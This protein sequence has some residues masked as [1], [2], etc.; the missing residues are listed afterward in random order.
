MDFRIRWALDR[1]NVAARLVEVERKADDA[2]ARAANS[3]ENI[4]ARLDDLARAATRIEQA[5]ANNAE[6][7]TARLDDLAR[8]ATR[9]EQAFANTAENITARLD[10]LA[11]TATPIERAFATTAGMLEARIEGLDRTNAQRLIPLQI[12]AEKLDA[13]SDLLVQRNIIGLGQELAVR[14]AAGYLLAPVEDP[15]VL[16][17]LIEGRGH[18]EPGTTAVLQTLLHPGDIMVDVGGHIGTL[19]LPAARCVG[20]AGRVI[21]LEPAPRLADLLRRTMVL[22]HIG[23]VDVHECAAGEVEAVA[24]FALSAQTGHNSLFP[25]DDTMQQIEVTVRPLDALIPPGTTVHVVKVDAEGAELQVWRGMRRILADN[26]AVAVLLEF[27]PE[28]LVRVGVS[29]AEWF[30]E[31]T[32]HG[33]TPWEIEEETGRVRPLRTA[34]LE[35]VYSFNVLLLRD[36]P[37]DRGLV[38]A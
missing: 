33:H 26:P 11:R 28:H 4:T 22:N 1:S 2:A 12:A 20:A 31:V 24:H 14:T 13:R 30:A 19:A 29:V 32:A 18:L 6:N 34:G 35:D 7:I 36:A 5:F 8:A 37:T 3:A 23:W 9:I 27:G 16:V 25:T 17:G 10:D 21:A 15:A 38:L